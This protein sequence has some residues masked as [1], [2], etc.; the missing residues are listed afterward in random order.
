M[1]VTAT[2]VQNAGNAAIFA[3]LHAALKPDAVLT[4]AESLKPYECDGL[5]AYRQLPLAAVLPSTVKEVQDVLKAAYE[6]GT[7]V[8][9]RGSGTGCP[10]APRPKPMRY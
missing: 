2:P 1:T 5:S 7:K 9:A 8:I 4:S 10:A 3:R 6:T